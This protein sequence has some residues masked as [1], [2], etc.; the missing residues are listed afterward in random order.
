MA[1]PP[2]CHEPRIVTAA[3]KASLRAELRARR[4]NYVL[5]LSADERTALEA[6]AAEHLWPLVG[7]ARIVAFYI[8][9]GSE[10][11]CTPLIRQARAQGMTVLLP[12]VTSR[13]TPL[14]FLRWDEDVALESGWFGLRQPPADSPEIA[15][16]IIV[17]PLLGFDP[18]RWRIGQG[19][20]FYDRAFSSHRLARRIGLAWTAQQVA[21]IPR[22]PWDE[23]LEVIVTELGL[24]QGSDPL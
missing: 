1:V 14:R 20:G 4:D 16:E 21:E 24:I 19:A 10:M 6:R 15:P 8:A 12:Y 18:A 3:A 17:A 22:D 13:A 9:E 2:P 7:A 23:Q 5:G 11:S